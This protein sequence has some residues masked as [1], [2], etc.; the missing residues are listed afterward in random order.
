MKV[1]VDAR[2]LTE[3]ITGVGR[4]TFEMCHA[5]TESE[6]TLNLYTPSPV[7]DSI[8][9]KLVNSTIKSSN[10]YGR[11]NRMVWSQTELPKLV[12]LDK[13]D[14]YWGPAHRIPESL[15]KKIARVV[16]V[17]DF[18]WKYASETMR[19]LSRLVEKV[20]MP[21]AIK[22]SDLIITDS[23][24]TSEELSALFPKYKSKIRTIYLGSTKFPK[25]DKNYSL[26]HYGVNKKYFLFVG[27]LEPR[28]NL[29]RLIEAYSKLPHE[30]KNSC[31]LLIVGGK[32][33]GNVNIDYITKKFDVVD[34]VKILGYVDDCVLASLY[35]NA[36]F[37]AM[38]SL[39]E[40]FGLPIVEAMNFGLPILTSNCSSMPEIA[41]SASILV[42]PF[43]VDSIKNGLEVL[44]QSQETRNR[45]SIEA[46]RLAR[47]FSWL[48]ASDEAMKVFHEAVEIRKSKFKYF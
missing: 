15:N 10:Y 11:I 48:K 34:Y 32:G 38:P 17:H 3:S 16:T 39:Y 12:N 42:N 46:K 13:V 22:L 33:W 45:L 20:L 8:V 36:T 6:L 31:N 4:Y 30:T 41:S 2:L 18:V 24:S 7:K 27:T 40:G 29:T 14:L 25:P 37:L 19:P 21:R 44:I 35:E 1:A 43:S 26:N 5:L 9:K 23:H 28:K 47:N